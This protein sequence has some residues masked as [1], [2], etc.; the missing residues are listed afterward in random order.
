MSSCL[1]E[2]NANLART[3]KKKIP[4]NKTQNPLVKIISITR[5][6]IEKFTFARFTCDGS[7][8]DCLHLKQT[9]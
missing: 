1:F 8:E 9:Q 5:T 4:K 3:H 6:G 7:R 2:V